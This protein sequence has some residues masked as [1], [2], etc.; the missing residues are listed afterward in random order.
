MSL[1]KRPTSTRTSATKTGSPAV[2]LRVLADSVIAMGPGNAHLLKAVHAN[3]SIS[4]A[5]A[6]LWG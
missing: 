4:A 5:A 1:A 2:R 3:G 6:A